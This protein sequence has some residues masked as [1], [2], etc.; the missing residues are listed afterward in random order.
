MLEY[1][2]LIGVEVVE[3][4]EEVGGVGGGVLCFNDNFFV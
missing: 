3:L 2:F 4:R 1:I